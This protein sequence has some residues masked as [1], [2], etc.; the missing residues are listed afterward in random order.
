MTEMVRKNKKTEVLS[1][2]SIDEDVFIALY[3]QQSL[4]I[5]MLYRL[6]IEGKRKY[7]YNSLKKRLKKLEEH[8]YLH[9]EHNYIGK[10]NKGDKPIHKKFYS[11]EKKGVKKA[12]GLLQYNRNKY[13]DY[14]PIE[15]YHFDSHELYVPYSDKFSHFISTQDIIINSINK[16]VEISSILQHFYDICYGT[17]KFFPLEYMIY[18]E[19]EEKGKE[20]KIIEKKIYSDGVMFKPNEIGEDDLYILRTKTMTVKSQ[21]FLNNKSPIL[22]ETD[23]STENVGRELDEKL[24]NYKNYLMIKKNIREKQPIYLVF[25]VERKKG[26]KVI[27]KSLRIDSIAKTISSILE[28]EIK[29]GMILPFVTNEEVASDVIGLIMNHSKEEL[30]DGAP[31]VSL[32]TKH[33]KTI[34]KRYNKQN[35]YSDKENLRHKEAPFAISK[36]L[37]YLTDERDDEPFEVFI[38][39][40]L[41][42]DVQ[43]ILNVISAQKYLEER[44]IKGVV[45]A[46]CLSEEEILSKEVVHSIKVYRENEPIEINP[47]EN[48]I[49]TTPQLFLDGHGWI[50][51]KPDNPLLKPNL[52]KKEISN[53]FK[54]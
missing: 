5:D 15:K 16:T 31:H 25:A 54:I 21:Y 44:K 6:I 41:M 32:I 13:V 47:S 3:F 17:G 45:V 48:V 7:A 9:G 4:S 14:R 2:G 23:M 50:Y 49:F 34:D 33:V 11:L 19:E 8:G 36:R 37:E 12:L 26:N 22:I 46:M 18:M 51:E 40:M 24:H 53:V 10:R 42:G 52:V 29:K 39:Y 35:E 38:Q 43:G 27:N 28:E 1:L 20:T 30:F